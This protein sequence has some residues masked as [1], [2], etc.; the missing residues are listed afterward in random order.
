[1]MSNKQ[2]LLSNVQVGIDFV[3]SL[4]KHVKE[5][6]PG[7]T[8]EIGIKFSNI[9]CKVKT[10]LKQEVKIEAIRMNY[11]QMLYT[12]PRYVRNT[13]YQDLFELNV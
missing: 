12:S 11:L 13:L 9:L 8:V 5:L 3:L 2:Y 6:K 10:R 7:N 1:M 4:C